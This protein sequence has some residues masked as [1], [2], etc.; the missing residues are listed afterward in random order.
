[1]RYRNLVARLE[2]AIRGNPEDADVD[3]L[4]AGLPQSVRN[5]PKCVYTL[6]IR[7]HRVLEQAL[8]GTR[9]GDE[10]PSS[11]AGA[12]TLAAVPAEATQAKPATAT[13]KSSAAGLAAAGAAWTY[14]TMAAPGEAARGRR[15][16]V[17]GH[18]VAVT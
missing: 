7:L 5:D 14:G 12:S 18:D 8:S 13:A 1:M 4:C 17:E 16:W 11:S 15:P 3:A 6:K 2:E 9:L 10:Q